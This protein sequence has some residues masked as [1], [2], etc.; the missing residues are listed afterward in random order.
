MP[1]PE[2]AAVAETVAEQAE[3]AARTLRRR[4]R[5]GAILLVEVALLAALI[6]AALP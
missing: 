3:Q 1:P 4:L 5:W 2:F 6:Y